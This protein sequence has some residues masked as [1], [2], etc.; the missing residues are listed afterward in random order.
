MK[1]QLFSL[2][3]SY[4]MKKGRK[5][6]TFPTMPCLA[7]QIMFASDEA[8]ARQIWNGVYVYA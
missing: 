6:F 4:D 8:Q 2:S 5:P 3:S 1:N 7:L